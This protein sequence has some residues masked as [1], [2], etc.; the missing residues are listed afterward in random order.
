MASASPL[1]ARPR[2]LVTLALGA[3]L[4]ASAPGCDGDDAPTGSDAG[5]AIGTAQQTAC[6]FGAGVKGLDVSYYQGTVDWN[7][8][9]G[10]GWGWAIARVSHSAEFIDPE[11]PNN[12]QRIKEAGMVR[13]AYQYFEP[14]ED[15]VGQAQIM[16]DAVGVLGD[17]DLPCVI[18]VEEGGATSS[19]YI[20]N[21]HTWID[22]VEAAT[23]KTPIIYT[24]SYFWDDNLGTSEFNEHPLWIAHYTTDCPRVP[25]SWEGDWTFWQYTDT[26]PIPGI[27]GNVDKNW[28][29]GDAAALAALAAAPTG[30][31]AASLVEVDVPT[32][33]LAGETF[34]VTVRFTNS[35]TATWDGSTLLGTSEPRDRP[36]DFADASWP[37]DHRAA[38]VSGTVAPGA[39][40]TFAFAMTAPD[41]PGAYVEH[42]ALVQEG[43]TWFSDVGGPSDDAVRITLQVLDPGGAGSGAGGAGADDDGDADGADVA[44]G[45][46]TGG[47]PASG[48][49]A[50]DAASNDIEGDGCAIPAAGGRPGE[51][52]MFATFVVFGAALLGA[53]RRRRR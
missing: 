5:D 47:S 16:I 29:K 28:F 4:G 44:V 24:G 10:D 31:Y 26:G 39:E 49:G 15:P 33:V 22:M 17:G 48:A 43:V 30:E 23:G 21:V 37:N 14:N 40:H 34:E 19:T 53:M 51:R 7:A 35:G 45:A 9:A 8:V 2:L 13:G 6:D 11:F 25:E 36:S 27:P 1:R 12:W 3:A 46:G 50:A 52:T 42:F 38:A 41:A 32:S 18:D 20:A